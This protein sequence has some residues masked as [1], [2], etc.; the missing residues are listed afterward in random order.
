ML[1]VPK[2][3]FSM[4]RNGSPLDESPAHVVDLDDSILIS[5]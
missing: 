2:G 3:E 1:L 5:T 4:G